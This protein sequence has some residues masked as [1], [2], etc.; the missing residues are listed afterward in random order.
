MQP[1]QRNKNK[2]NDKSTTGIFARF[3]ISAFFGGLIS[4]IILALIV[5]LTRYIYWSWVADYLIQKLVYAI[6]IVP[7]CWGFLG[8]FFFDTMISIASKIFE[9]F[10][11]SLTS[12]YR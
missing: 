3:I 11:D 1:R 6:W 2:T 10:L 4:F 8:I 7:L 12:R 9:G 5:G